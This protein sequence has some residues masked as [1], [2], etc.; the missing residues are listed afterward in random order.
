MF[1]ESDAGKTKY[2]LTD[3]INFPKSIINYYIHIDETEMRRRKFFAV[4][5][6]ELYMHYGKQ[7]AG[8][9]L[10]EINGWCPIARAPEKKWEWEDTLKKLEGLRDRYN[11]KSLT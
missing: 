8:L 11:F 1:D 2:Q 5:V 9:K 4:C 7:R 6:P 3:H 10:A